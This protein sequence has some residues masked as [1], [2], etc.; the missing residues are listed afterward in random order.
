[1]HRAN[2]N[3]HFRCYT[4]KEIEN[5]GKNFWLYNFSAT[6]RAISAHANSRQLHNPG[7]LHN[8]EQHNGA[9]FVNE[10]SELSIFSCVMLQL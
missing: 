9:Q 7:Q 6:Q 3:A 1:M 8:P 5:Q 2:C 10:Q 4:V